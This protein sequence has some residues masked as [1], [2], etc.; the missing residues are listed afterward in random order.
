MDS[1]LGPERAKAL[2]A[3]HAFLG[4]DNTGRFSR[5]GKATWL[6]VYLKADGEV[7]KALQMLSDATEDTDD[8]LSTLATF[9]SAAYS[10]KGIQI[11]SIPELRWHL[12]C[13]HMAESDKLPP[14]PGAL[15]QHILRVQIQA[16][17]LGQ[18]SVAQ[19]FLDSLKHGFYKDTTGQ[20]KPVTTEVLPAPRPSLRCASAERLFYS[21]ISCRSNNL[22]C[23]DLCQCGSQCQNDGTLG[24]TYCWP[25]TVM[26][27]SDSTS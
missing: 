14:T 7:V 25:V 21:S 18:A 6:Q 12:F 15:K 19:Q 24:M 17:V 13:K 23:T 20:V 4:A 2:P 9:V 27:M 22:S 10:P 16:T 1:S 8:L 11:A 26:M 3:F 5:I